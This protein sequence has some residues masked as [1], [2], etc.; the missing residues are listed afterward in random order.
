MLSTWRRNWAGILVALAL[1]LAGCGS[2]PDRPHPAVL[3]APEPEARPRRE[4]VPRWTGTAAD[5]ILAAEVTLVLRPG[6][7]MK[8]TVGEPEE[9]PAP[10]PGDGSDRHYQVTVT[11][12]NQGTEPVVLYHDCHHLI[13]LKGMTAIWDCEPLEPVHLAPGKEYTHG[14]VLPADYLPQP[15]GGELVYRLASEVPD[16]P[17]RRLPVTLR[18]ERP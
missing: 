15:V 1:A 4:Q 8:G 11:V 6:K 5:G 10:E 7:V 16:G 12:R 14:S 3:P 17:E 2:D 18:L 9:A 13:W